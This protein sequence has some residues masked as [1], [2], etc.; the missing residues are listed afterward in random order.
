MELYSLYQSVRIVLYLYNGGVETSWTPVLT[1]ALAGGIWLAFFILQGVGVYTMAKRR[2]MKRKGLAFVPFANIWYIGKLAGECNVFG[3]K[4]KRAGLYAMLA[5]IVTT[6]VCAL[7]VAAEIFLFLSE[8]VPLFDD[9]GFYWTDLSGFTD[10]VYKFYN[11]S[12]YILSIFQLIYEI[13][14]LIL[15][16]GL[17]KKYYP[18]NYLVL[19]MLSLFIPL[20]RFVIVFVLRNRNAV[21]Y[22]A[23][24]RARREAYMR[25]QQQYRNTY[26]NPYG[27]GYGSPYNNPYGNPY[28]GN[29][30]AQQ[31]RPQQPQQEPEDPFSE[32]SGGKSTSSADKNQNN[33][34]ATPNSEN[35]PDEF[36]N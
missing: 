7:A 3:Q 33:G 29:P 27:G 32:F 35:D 19:G 24:M 4:M 10:T 12:D 8:G 34:N 25:Q 11:I 5:Q 36:F 1:I 13:L 30:Y 2:G 31:P 18:K 6:V 14:M 17:Y 22:D 9:L 20:S 23:Y 16:F 21:D 28:G 15:L 26:G